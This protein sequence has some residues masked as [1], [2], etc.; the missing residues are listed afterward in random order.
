M[1]IILG[2]SVRR[3]VIGVRGCG[4]FSCSLELWWFSFLDLFCSSGSLLMR[5]RFEWSKFGVHFLFDRYCSRSLF[6]VLS[7]AG[8]CS[9]SI[10]WLTT[11]RVHF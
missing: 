5:Q 3:V 8:A 10:I 9:R 2:D 7:E 1:A 4:F 11:E 6:Q